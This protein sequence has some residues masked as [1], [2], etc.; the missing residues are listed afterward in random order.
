[1][2]EDLSFFTISEIKAI[3]GSRAA[4]DEEQRRYL[5]GSVFKDDPYIGDEFVGIGKTREEREIEIRNDILSHL[6]SED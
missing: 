3:Y 4:A 1:M 6:N 2:K 5:E